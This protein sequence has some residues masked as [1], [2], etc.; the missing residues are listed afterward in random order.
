[1]QEITWILFEAFIINER[2]DNYNIICSID[3]YERENQSSSF[4]DLSSGRG[5]PLTITST[6]EALELLGTTID[7]IGCWIKSI[8]HN[9]L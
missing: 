7:F 4:Y 6:T 9:F 1:M 8:E 3:A 2:S 5:C